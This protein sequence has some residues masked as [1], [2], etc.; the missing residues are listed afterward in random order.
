MAQGFDGIKP[1]GGLGWIKS[2]HNSNSHR[3][4]ERQRMVALPG[5]TEHHR[6]QG[7]AG[8]Q[9]W[10]QCVKV[11]NCEIHKTTYRASSS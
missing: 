7:D 5:N 8:N 10:Q 1:G 3:N 4:A 9:R 6:N 11:L 2:K